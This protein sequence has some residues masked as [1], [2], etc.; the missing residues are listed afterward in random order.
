MANNIFINKFMISQKNNKVFVIAEAGVSHF[1]SLKKAKK[2]IVAKI[3]IRKGE[4]LTEKNLTTKRPG[5][6]ISP[7]KWDVFLGKKAK[8]NYLKDQNI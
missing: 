2:L 3:N 7:D 6:G 8:K 4:I 5:F 1:G